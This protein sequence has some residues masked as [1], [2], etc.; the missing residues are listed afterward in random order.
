M[1]PYLPTVYWVKHKNIKHFSSKTIKSG[2]KIWES[3][4]LSWTLRA[5]TYG[6][7]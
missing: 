5:P 7:D 6:A 1:Q 2:N 4:L 3:I